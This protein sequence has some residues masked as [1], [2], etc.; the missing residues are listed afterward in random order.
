MTKLILFKIGLFG[1]F[2]IIA[3]AQDVNNETSKPSLNNI[4]P[5]KNQKKLTTEDDQNLRLRILSYNIH[6]A[7]GVDGK[8]DVPRIAQVILSVDPDLVALQEVDKNTIRTGKV[9]QDIELSRLTK[10]NSVFGSNI[11]FQGGQY[12]NAILS[13]FPIIKN[14]N[15]LLPNVDSGEQRGLLQ[16]Q[17]QISNKENVLFFSTHL[18]HRR[19]DTERLAS[20]KAINQIISLDNKSPAILAGDFNDVPDSPTLKELGKVWLRTN[21]K[22]LRTIPASKPSRQIDYIFV[23]PKERW[24]IIESQVLDEDTASDHRA[25]FSIIELIK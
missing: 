2:S 20:A 8:L 10:M 1:F 11:T 6:H 9:N 5:K 13:K 18:D 14:K 24:K 19:S 16:S 15:F 4:I 7:E 17:I 3:N 21:K 22:I 25:I 23:Q 12:G